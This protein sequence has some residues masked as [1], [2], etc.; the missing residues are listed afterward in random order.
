[1]DGNTLLELKRKLTEFDEIR[2]AFLFGSRAGGRP[3]L[4]SD[5]DI[6]VYLSE[7]LSSAERFNVRLRLA[8]ALQEIGKV[9]VVILNDA[10]PLLA[11]R[12]LQGRR[13]LVKDPTAYV[14]FFV[15]IEAAAGDEHYWR[16]LHIDARA[17]RLKEGRFG[18]P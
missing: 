10:P 14:R 12:V 13:L 15:K 2:F 18:R 5:W 3:H 11:Q 16:R 1:M 9:D 17:Q 7:A 8:T 6:G 4:D